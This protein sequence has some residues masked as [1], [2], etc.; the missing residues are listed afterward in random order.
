MNKTIEQP[1]GY[2]GEVTLS[3]KNKRNGKVTKLVQYNHALGGISRVF[4]YAMCG[5]DISKMIPTFLDLCCRDAEVAESQPISMLLTPIL[6]TGTH[7]SADTSDVD[8][9]GNYYYFAEYDAL[10]TSGNRNQVS[11]NGPPIY[12]YLQNSSGEKLVELG[13]KDINGEP[14][15]TLDGIVG[16]GTN[17]VINWKIKLCRH[18]NADEQPEGE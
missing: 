5:Y 6:L 13:L 8:T 3:I 4:A 16:D 2:Q 7:Y 10:V 18:T 17:L 1:L 12:I 15:K 9:L 14:L 11:N